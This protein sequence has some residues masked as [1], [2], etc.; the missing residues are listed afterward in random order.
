[1]Y[2]KAMKAKI[3]IFVIV[4]AAVVGF[5]AWVIWHKNAPS[6]AGA[7]SGTSADA[8]STP[9]AVGDGYK[10]ATYKIE[11]QDITLTSGQS[12]IPI[13][14][15]SASQLVTQYFGNVAT[16][17]LNNDG[18]PDAAF[19]LTQSGGGSG[20]FFYIVAAIKTPGGFHGTNGI[21][22]GD[23]IAPQ[24]TQIASGTIIVNYAD[25]SAGQ[26][27]TAQPSVGVTKYFQVQNGVLVEVKG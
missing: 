22:L 11:N 20:T 14:P 12:A 7:N 8:S 27:M 16:G 5:G 2:N 13:V 25:R 9:P 19:I 24:N 4:C 3:W 1:M 26:P 10:N 6:S 23:R 17:D 21:L 15:G 18:I